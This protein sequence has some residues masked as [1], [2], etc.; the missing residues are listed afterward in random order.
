MHFGEAEIVQEVLPGRDPIGALEDFEDAIAEHQE[1]RSG[2][3]QLVCAAEL[4][5][6]KTA[7]G[8]SFGVQAGGCI[9]AWP[10][11]QQERRRMPGAGEDQ[12]AP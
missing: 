11:A 1:A 10:G 5:F 2:G 9:A 6:G 4:R 8:G 12:F 3:H 7:Y